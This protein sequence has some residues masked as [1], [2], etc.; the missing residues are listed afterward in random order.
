MKIHETWRKNSPEL[1]AALRG[2][3]PAF[4][5][6]HS[7]G[8]LGSDV[9]AFFYHSVDASLFEADLSFLAR[10]KY[11]TISA[12]N[13]LDHL[14]G[15]THLPERSV[16][17]TID[18]GARNLYEIAFP[19]LGQFGMK[20]VA[21]IAPGFHKEEFLQLLVDRRFGAP[22][23]S[24]PQIR[25]MH[26]SGL[27]DFQSHTYEH[28]YIPRWPEPIELEGSDPEIV[29][30]LIGPARPIADDLRLAKETLEQ[31]LN[32]VVRHVAF[33]RFYGTKEAVRAGSQLGYEGYWW[34]TMPHRSG[35]RPGQ[36]PSGIVRL[37]GAFLRRLPGEGREPLRIA[38]RRRY[39]RSASALPLS[40][41]TPLT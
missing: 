18:D 13:L 35:N 16:V 30:S 41:G 33:P 5:F 23:L 9:P 37:H 11:T 8:S 2:G 17:I 29:R 31:N 40:C 39:Q 38:L 28:R 27:I 34:G 32:K 15:R 3:L 26:E 21:F 22:P 12:D 36:S 19:L 4:C 25:E 7:P 10:N 6:A 1:I 14:N 24:W 20:A